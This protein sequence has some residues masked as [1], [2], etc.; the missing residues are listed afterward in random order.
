MSTQ[1]KQARLFRRSV[2]L[3]IMKEIFTEWLNGAQQLQLARRT[4]EHNIIRRYKEWKTST[5]KKVQSWLSFV[6]ETNIPKRLI[7]TFFSQ[8]VCL[9]ERCGSGK[10]KKQTRHARV[11]ETRGCK[12]G[13]FSSN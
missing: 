2:E 8:C 4:H 13:K 7:G 3:K 6:H 5:F 12:L 10:D 9:L 1:R 11:Q